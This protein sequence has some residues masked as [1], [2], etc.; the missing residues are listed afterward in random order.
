MARTETFK[1]LLDRAS[2]PV[3]THIILA[4]LAILR[5]LDRQRTANERGESFIEAVL[6]LMLLILLGS[7]V[8]KFLVASKV[9]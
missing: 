4:Q 9:L 6:T 1:S 8:V 7:M 2:T 3:Q 5:K